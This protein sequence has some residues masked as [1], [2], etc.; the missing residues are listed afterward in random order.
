MRKLFETRIPGKSMCF[1]SFSKSPLDN[2]KNARL[3]FAARIKYDRNAGRKP[4]PGAIAAL[5]SALTGRGAVSAFRPKAGAMGE[6]PLPPSE[7]SHENF[8]LVMD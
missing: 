7:E 1:C 4:A 2:G 8:S 3:Y 5:H 6:L